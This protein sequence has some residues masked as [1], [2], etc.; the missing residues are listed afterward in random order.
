MF[1]IRNIQ[2]KMSIRWFEKYL[3]Y[4]DYLAAAQLY[5]KDNFFLKKPLAL[6]HIKDRILGH[7]GTV[8]GQNFIYAHC[9][10][11]RAHV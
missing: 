9:K 5:L 2:Q 6:A 11:G 8:P 4:V 1:Q 7:W 3:R 10:I